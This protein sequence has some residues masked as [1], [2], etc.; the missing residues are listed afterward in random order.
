MR[1]KDIIVKDEVDNDAYSNSGRGLTTP[2]TDISLPD[3]R[4]VY[5]TN[6]FGTMAIVSTFV[7]MLL[8][9]K[10]L[11]INISSIS[12]Q[13][14]YVFGSVYCS[15]KAALDAYSRT[16]RLELA[17]FGV[18]VMVVRAGTVKSNIATNRFGSLK[19]GSLYQKA[20]WL[21]ERRFG[22]SQ[23]KESGGGGPVE[24]DV[25]ARKLVDEALK[26]SVVGGN[27]FFAHMCRGLL[28]LGRQDWWYLGGM[29]RL[30]YLGTWIGEWV[31]DYGAWRRFRLSEL[32]DIVIK[33]E[34]Q[35]SKERKHT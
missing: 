6:L 27:G 28:R 12:A 17:P 29:A 26:G 22:W 13:V 32:E 8:P 11:I 20:S 15:S 5:E 23:K 24:T 10:G 18:H 1:R 14:P 31:S 19:E 2:A 4:A 30:V 34:E 35:T 25:F 16:L 33:E 9:T 21:Y 3:A 7:P